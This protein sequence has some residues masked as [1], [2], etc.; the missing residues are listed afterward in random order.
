MREE[1][2]ERDLDPS[3]TIDACEKSAWIG[4]RHEVMDEPVPATITQP[5]VKPAIH[6]AGAY[7]V[8]HAC[9]P[10]PLVELGGAREPGLCSEV[11]GEEGMPEPESEQGILQSRR[12]AGV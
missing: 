11:S 12:L 9:A 10:E 4:A 2:P 6:G 5:L 7:V 8:P 3:R 1:G